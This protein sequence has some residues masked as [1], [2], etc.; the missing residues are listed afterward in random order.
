MDRLFDFSTG[1]TPLLVSVPH[2]GTFVPDGIATRMTEAALATPDTDW[3]VPLLYDF[4]AGLGASTIMATHSRYVIDLNRDPAGRPLY[5]GGQN[6]ELVPLTTFDFEPIYREGSEPDSSEVADRRI[7]FWAPYHDRLREELDRLRQVY[8]FA[9]LLEGHSIRSVVDRFFDG[10]IPD[11]NLGTAEGESCDAALGE[12]VF[13]VLDRSPYDAVWD[14]RFTGGYI[15][16]HFGD[17]AGNIHAMQLELTWKNYMEE[18][19]PYAYL[20]ERA[21]RLKATLRSMVEEILDWAAER[22]RS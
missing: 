15:T 6:T 18:I 3:Y 22:A 17:P 5:P 4:A 19:P 16:R 21:A 8:G 1:T 20:P 7:R 12:R 9:I 14:D 11:L 10:V 2:G 13:R